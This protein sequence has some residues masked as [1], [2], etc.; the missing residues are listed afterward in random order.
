MD[1]GIRDAQNM[2][3]AMAPAASAL[4]LNHMKDFERSPK[5]YDAIITGDPGVWEAR[6]WQN[7]A[8]SVDATSQTI[9]MTVAWRFLMQT[10][11][12]PVRGGSG[13][14]CSA[15]TLASYYLPRVIWQMET[16]L[17]YSDGSALISG[18]FQ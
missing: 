13:C 12:T 3:A 17:I 15:V 14:G 1:A 11:S 4:I 2:G 18:Q 6:S 5:D 8:V 7:F 9:T 16:D 10:S